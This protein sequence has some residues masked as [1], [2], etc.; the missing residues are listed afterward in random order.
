MKGAQGG[1]K[2]E[3][4]KLP[5]MDSS[6]DEYV[7]GK[8][9]GRMHAKCMC[10]HTTHFTHDILHFYSQYISTFRSPNLYHFIFFCV[11]LLLPQN[12]RTLKT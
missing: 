4:G 6:E 1:K 11:S 8:R 5:K 12:T 2:N 9:I 7:L 10:V 3:R